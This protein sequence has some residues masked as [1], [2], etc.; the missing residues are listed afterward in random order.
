VTKQFLICVSL[1]IVFL[2][3]S[4][5]TNMR[6]S[7]LPEKAYDAHDLPVP[8]NSA[9]SRLAE[10]IASASL[11]GVREVLDDG[12]DVNRVYVQRPVPHVEIPFLYSGV[13]HNNHIPMLL[14]DRG[15]SLNFITDEGTTPLAATAYRNDVEQCR[16]FLSYGADLEYPTAKG[17][18]PLDRAALRGSAGTVGLLLE[19]GAK[20]TSKTLGNALKGEHGD[21]HLNYGAIRAIVEYMIANGLDVDMEDILLAA[22]T[23]NSEK[24]IAL[25][26]AGKLTRKNLYVVASNVVAFCS[27][28]ALKA[29]VDNSYLLVG[30]T[31]YDSH[32]PI[33][34]AARHGN[35]ETVAWMLENWPQYG[36]DF[37]YPDYD[38]LLQAVVS[39]QHA[40]AEFLVDAGTELKLAGDDV[41]VDSVLRRAVDNRDAK[42]VQILLS[43]PP[44]ISENALVDAIYASTLN[45]DYDSTRLLLPLMELSP[46][47]EA[48]IWTFAYKDLDVLKLC[49]EYYPLPKDGRLLVYASQE[50]NYDVAEYLVR[51]GID[52]NSYVEH[53]GAPLENAVAGGF[54]DIV[55]LLADNG[56]DVNYVSKTYGSML[57]HAAKT[58][59]RI[60]QRLIDAGAEM[61]WQL[62]SNGETPLMAAIKANKA[63][64]AEIL[65]NEGADASIKNNEGMTAKDLAEKSDIPEIRALFGLE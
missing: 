2:T 54:L 48:T 41:G 11:E 62:E 51:Q 29:C 32:S 39:Q 31:N 26:G 15:A 19:N 36:W 43:P 12:A 64:C 52:A 37:P 10:A 50:G 20:I 14:L 33:E 5:C 24:V 58:S 44:L 18:T 25:I 55:E 13:Q 63:K 22:I 27:S 38:A 56:A 59:Y 9:D 65:L 4:S 45:G 34:T 7:D 17:E 28:E 60:T 47:G 53:I 1:I 16:L 46:D 35:V 23:G 57:M 42:M 61:D 40:V 30:N 49:A 21:G 8:Q 6:A 3:Q